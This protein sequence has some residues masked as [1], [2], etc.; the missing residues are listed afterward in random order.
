LLQ[1]AL[2]RKDGCKEQL[3][4]QFLFSLLPLAYF[5]KHRRDACRRFKIV[6]VDG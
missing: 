5:S 4:R 3:A 2:L 6:E 1:L